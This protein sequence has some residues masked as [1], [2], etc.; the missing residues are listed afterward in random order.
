MVTMCTTW[1]N[2]KKFLSFPTESV[3][4]F[5]TILTLNSDYFKLVRLSVTQTY[6]EKFHISYIH[7]MFP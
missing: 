4:V 7:Y 1:F 5:R 3:Y 6:I 2:I